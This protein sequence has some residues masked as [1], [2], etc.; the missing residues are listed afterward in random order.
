MGFT[1]NCL[2]TK[3]TEELRNELL[4]MGRIEERNNGNSWN[5]DCLLCYDDK[6]IQLDVFDPIDLIELKE[7][8]YVNCMDKEDMFL[9]IASLRDDSDINQFFVCDVSLGSIN[10]PESII[11]KGSLMKCLTDKWLYP[12]NKFDSTGIPS[13]KATVQEL[14]EHFK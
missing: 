5:Y 10:Y 2:I 1:N 8:E 7:D 11:P 3:N 14:I 4:K 6:F 12:K 9:A 13:H